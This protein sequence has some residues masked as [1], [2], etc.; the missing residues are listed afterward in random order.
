[1]EQGNT[2]VNAMPEPHSPLLF[3]NFFLPTGSTE[4]RFEMNGMNMFWP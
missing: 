1:M 2:L 3:S 4:R